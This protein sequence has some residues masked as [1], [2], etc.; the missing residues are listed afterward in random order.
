MTITIY[1]SNHQKYE[2][3]PFLQKKCTHSFISHGIKFKV[4]DLWMILANPHISLDTN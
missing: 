3:F 2:S 1:P 4:Q